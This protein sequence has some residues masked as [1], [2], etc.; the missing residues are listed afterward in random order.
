[1]IKRVVLFA[2]L[3]AAGVAYADDYKLG[4]IVIAHPWARPTAQS[5]K[6]GAAYLSLENKGNEADKLVSAASPVAGKTQIHKT[7]NEGG[8]TKMREA[9]GGVDLAPGATLAFKPGS[10]HIML[11]D[12][13]QKLEEGQRIPLTLTFAKAGS[14]NIEVDVEKRS[15]SEH[16]GG[17]MHD[18]GMTGMDHKMH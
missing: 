2:S 6:I 14:I 7:T 12:L 15:G 16:S 8:V 1:M 18:Q 13:K 17:P 5:V 10:Y 3:F 11:L 9:G 4:N